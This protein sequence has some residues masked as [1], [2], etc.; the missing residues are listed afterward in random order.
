LTGAAISLPGLA[1]GESRVTRST[2]SGGQR[3]ASASSA[4]RSLS[5]LAISGSPRVASH[6]IGVTGSAASAA[7]T[8]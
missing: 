3:S 8:S 5:R 6:G 1:T 2:G 4:G 7:L